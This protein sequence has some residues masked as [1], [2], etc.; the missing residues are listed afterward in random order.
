MARKRPESV[1]GHAT[2]Q[3]V[4]AADRLD[5]TDKDSLDAAFD[6]FAAEREEGGVPFRTD[7]DEAL[8]RE[9]PRAWAAWC[10]SVKC[11]R[12]LARRRG[13]HVLPRLEGMPAAEAEVWNTRHLLLCR[14]RPV[15]FPSGKLAMPRTFAPSRPRIVNPTDA[16]LAELGFAAEPLDGVRAVSRWWALVFATMAVSEG[17]LCE[18]CGQILPPTPGGRRSRRRRCRRCVNAAGYRKL[19][20]AEPGRL[21]QYW[22]ESKSRIRGGR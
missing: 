4:L 13:A 22:T 7:V 15:R 18:R 20:Q 2:W 11:M 14:P 6:F 10:S 9:D 19:K 1:L 12:T 16:Q 5:L 21:R 17:P 3:S 8:L